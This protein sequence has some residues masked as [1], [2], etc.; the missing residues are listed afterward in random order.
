MF[1][2]FVWNFV[3]IYNLIAQLEMIFFFLPTF[4][5]TCIKDLAKIL[6]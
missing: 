2:V 6:K 5:G 4:Y 3:T 1:D